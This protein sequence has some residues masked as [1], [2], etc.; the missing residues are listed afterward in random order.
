MHQLHG[1]SDSWT[2]YAELRL[3]PQV[4]TDVLESCDDLADKGELVDMF[5]EYLVPGLDKDATAK[6]EATKCALTCA[7]AAS[8]GA[9]EAEST[10]RSLLP[11]IWKYRI[12]V[13]GSQPCRLFIAMAPMDRTMSGAHRG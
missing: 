10:R 11:L 4:L 12:E 3:S 7:V 8:H 13:A 5:L 9:A 6:P 2:G 1:T